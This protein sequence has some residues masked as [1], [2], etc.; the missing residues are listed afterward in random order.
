MKN[1]KTEKQNDVSPDIKRNIYKCFA[2]F[3]LANDF[4]IEPDI[5]FS[6]ICNLSKLRR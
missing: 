4:G 6:S 5:L 3:K 1:E 2:L